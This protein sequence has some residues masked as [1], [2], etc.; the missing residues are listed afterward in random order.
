M[1]LNKR[2]LTTKLLLL[3]LISV[4]T[5]SIFSQTTKPVKDSASI[6]SAT[7][8]DTLIYTL[9]K[10]LSKADSLHR[11]YDFEKAIEYY[12]LVIDNSTDSLTIVEIEDKI[13]RSENGVNMLK[14]AL[15]PNVIAK[16]RTSSED[17]FLQ[18]SE[19]GDK[20]WVPT[21]NPFV[22]GKHHY[23]QAIYA[24][25]H[26]SEIYYSAPDESNCWNIY[27]SYRISDTLWSEPRLM[28]EHI[29]SSGDEIFPFVSA[30]GKELYFSSNGLH[31]MG[32]YDL[33]V[34]YWDPEEGDWGVPV[35]LGF[36]YSSPGD[37]IF[38]YNTPDGKYSLFA[39]VQNVDDPQIELIATEY[40]STPIK[41]S[42]SPQEARIIAEFNIPQTSTNQQDKPSTPSSEMKEYSSLIEDMRKYRAEIDSN[43]VKLEKNRELYSSLTNED[44]RNLLESTI[45]KNESEIFEISRRLDQVM[46]RIQRVEMDFLAKGIIPKY[47]KEEEVKKEN[48]IEPYIFSLQQL[49]RVNEV[50]VVKSVPKFDYSFKISDVAVMAEN[51]TLPEGLIYQIQF[52]ATNQP[53]S[54]KSLRG[55]SPVFEKKNSS[56]KYIY[57]VGLFS[58]YDEGVSKLNSVRKLGF[59]SAF[60]VAFNSGKSLSV[61]QARALEKKNKTASLYQV[62]IEGYPQGMPDSMLSLLRELSNKDIGKLEIDKKNVYIVGPFTARNEAD[63]LIKKISENGFEG[64]SVEQLNI[65]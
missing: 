49:G 11:A 36:P 62:K 16:K 35:N 45:A 37:D 5:G 24:P 48:I 44:D 1:D 60:M 39:T 42:V 58:S 38:F 10:Y 25:E 22:S 65:Q 20:S 4:P 54:K 17:F 51:Q 8:K 14:F 52:M 19:M 57:T 6:A 34:S 50:E 55:L 13:L 27:T 18:I 53:A 59:S 40:I 32:G 31:G 21:P 12:D 23:Y 64:V 9:D 2:I 33:Y 63:N 56:G 29:T 3:S 28:N 26:I 15:S 61:P 30:D 41:S 7:P 46:E 43:T 47:E